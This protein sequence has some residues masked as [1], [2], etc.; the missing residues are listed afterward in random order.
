[1][2]VVIVYFVSQTSKG[3]SS[4][5]SLLKNVQNLSEM[6][7]MSV[8]HSIHSLSTSSAVCPLEI[9]SR[10]VALEGMIITATLKA[11]RINAL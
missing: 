1:V 9:F 11:L 3:N 6:V 7:F 10:N 4:I 2:F 8:S 5:F